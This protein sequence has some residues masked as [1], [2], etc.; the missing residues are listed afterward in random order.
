[1]KQG[2]KGLAAI[3][4]KSTGDSREDLQTCDVQG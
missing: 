1:M 3:N 2:S 4:Q